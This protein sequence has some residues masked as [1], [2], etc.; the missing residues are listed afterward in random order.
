MAP[1]AASG[2]CEAFRTIVSEFDWD[3]SIAMAV[4][5][6]ESGCR[7]D[8]YNGSNYNGSNDA[9]LFQINSIHVESGLITDS[10]RMDAKENVR[11]A[12][13]IYRGSGWKAWSVCSAKINCN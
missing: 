11:A 3:V 6:A 8:A 12:Y 2:G 13:A 9:G 5:R 7:P 1:V 4:M 10:G